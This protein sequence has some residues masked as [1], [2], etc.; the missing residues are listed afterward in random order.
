M[1]IKYRRELDLISP[2][3]PGKPVEDVQRELGLEQVVKLASNEN[4]YGF[5]PNVREAIIRALDSVNRYPDGN[6]TLLKEKIA[7][8]YGLR[9][10]MVLPTNGADEMLDLIAKTFGGR[11][12]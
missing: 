6:A 4:P 11:Q 2:Y 10:E 12:S 3:V 9:P 8:K 7:Q 5:S 1:K